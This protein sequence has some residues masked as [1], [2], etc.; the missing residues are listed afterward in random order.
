MSIALSWLALAAGVFLAT[1]LLDDVKVKGGF[2]SYMIIAAVFGVLNY[3][4]GWLL[5]AAI[6]IS[7]LFLG[8]VFAFVTRLVVDAILLLLTSK[9]SSRLEIRGF[10]P[11][12]VA[13]LVM[14]AVGTGAEWLVR[15]MS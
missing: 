12:L 13:A 8:F 14:S 1:V 2:G 15:Q 11:A 4:L 3:F 10:G 6:G 7:T 9:L 5:F